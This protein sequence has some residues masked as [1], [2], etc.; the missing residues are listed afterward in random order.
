MTRH[1]RS[2]SSSGHQYPVSQQHIPIAASTML[3]TQ[4]LSMPANYYPVPS[5]A[6]QFHLAPQPAHHQH[7]QHQQQEVQHPHQ[8]VAAYD[9]FL[10]TTVV[11]PTSHR[12]SS[13]AWSPQDDQQLIQARAQGLN[14][15][16]IKNTYFPSK[17]SNACRKRHERLAER[18]DSDDW[19]NVKLQRL[20]KEYM[21]MRKEIW[22][23]LASRTG[24]KWNIVEQK[25]S[26]SI[27]LPLSPLHV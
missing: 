21:T 18:R 11:L 26:F 2:V 25:V 24:E 10:D 17:T 7:Q 15:N 4:R 3:N 6:S 12:P 14:W 5:N 9:Q 27:K 19:D 23:E 13:G 8:S 22:S 1:T 20:A 16:Q